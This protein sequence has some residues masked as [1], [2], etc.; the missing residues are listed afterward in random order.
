MIN[1]P[2]D[3]DLSRREIDRTKHFLREELQVLFELKHFAVREE[4]RVEYDWR[5]EYEDPPAWMQQPW[6][7][8][9]LFVVQKT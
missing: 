1:L 6:P 9:W 4:S 8:D 7:W 3:A 5:E 2:T